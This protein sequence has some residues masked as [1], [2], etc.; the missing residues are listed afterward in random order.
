MNSMNGLHKH[1]FE[2][3]LMVGVVLSGIV[4]LLLFEDSSHGSTAAIII[5]L[6]CLVV[7][8][9]I[10]RRDKDGQHHPDNLYYMG[11][12]F[13]LASLVYSLVTLFLLNSDEGDISE[14]V[15]NLTGSFGIALIST[16]FGI[17][18]RILLLQKRDGGIPPLSKSGAQKQSAQQ[19]GHAES[20]QQRQFAHQSL[21]EAAFKLRQELTQTIADMSVFRRAMGQATK[22][23]VEEADK[24]RAAMIQQVEKAAHEQTRILSTL[25]ATTVDKLTAAIDEIVASIENVQKPLDE[26]VAQQTG[27][28]RHSV[29]LAEQSADQLGRSIQ[30]SSTKIISG[31]EKIGTAFNSVLESLQGVVRDLQSTSGDVQT[32]ASKYDSLN[33]GLRQSATL[34]ASVE[35]EVEQATKTLITATKAFSGSLTEAAEVTPQYTQQFEQLITALRQEA[36]QWQSMTQEVR[37][38]LVQAIKKLAETVKHS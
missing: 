34:F 19:D 25:S 7:Y 29:V 16:F 31:G 30:D 32:L 4:R 21:T 5:C 15:Y 18:F 6:F 11:L 37:M 22:E 14:R 17:L 8:F 27:R 28:V 24:A 10:A 26:L 13:T 20:E 36:E 33:A 9:I 35:G 12:L 3:L 23:T 2:T 38:S 1:L